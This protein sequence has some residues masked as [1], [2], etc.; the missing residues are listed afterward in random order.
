MTKP[1]FLIID[2]YPK[3]SRDQFD[4]VGMR[5]AG[6]L[7]ADMLLRYEPDAEYRIW[8]SSDPDA[9]APADE[10]LAD[11]AGVLWPGCN[12][13]IYHDDPRVHAHRDL[14]RRAYE[15]GVPQFG[16]CWGIQLACTVPGG[17]TEAHPKGRAMGLATKIRLTDEGKRHPMME[18]KPEV[19]SH[20]VSHDDYVT[21]LPEGAVCLASNDWA[22]IQAVAVEWQGGVFWA[23][24]YHPEYNLHELAR[25]IL[26]REEKLIRQGWFT[27]AQNMREYVEKLEAVYSAPEEH[28]A[29]RWQLKIDDDVIDE[30]IRQC[31]F[32]N[33]LKYI[34][35]PQSG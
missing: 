24:Q 22:P 32:A 3:E 25:L 12:L 23:V 8:Y 27:D 14:C 6:V 35:R 4:A 5:L 26:A 10:E 29:I 7:Y 30:G 13:T 2:G 21:G 9:A 28:K 15:A 1:R 19:Y 20:F 11:C 16:S 18:G 17:V 31:E 34:V 33:W